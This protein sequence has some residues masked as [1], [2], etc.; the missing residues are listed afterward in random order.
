[1][2]DTHKCT[3]NSRIC[4]SQRLKVIEPKLLFTNADLIKQCD[5]SVEN[6]FEIIKERSTHDSEAKMF[7]QI[8]LSVSEYAN[9]IEM[10][11]A[12]KRENAD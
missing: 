6:F 11:R 1:M 2:I 12:Y 4:S 9:F 7:I 10:M 3:R 8:L 5:I